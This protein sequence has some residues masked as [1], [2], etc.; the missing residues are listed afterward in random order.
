MKF[1][2]NIESLPDGIVGA[3]GGGLHKM[4]IGSTDGRQWA[5]IKK[6]G[7][8][9]DLREF[10]EHIAEKPINCYS[11]SIPG[12]KSDR[13]FAF[14][15]VDG[16]PF[17]IN[18]INACKKIAQMMYYC[19]KNHMQELW[20]IDSSE[21]EMLR[22]AAEETEYPPPAH[23]TMQHYRTMGWM[24]YPMTDEYS[25]ILFDTENDAMFCS[26]ENVT[27]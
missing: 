27:I 17:E 6:N 24:Y 25:E 3:L 5:N 20:N 19:K 9:E 23:L 11:F 21:E 26:A 8:D 2:L 1:G 13:V 16:Q 10:F 4:L 12:D 18:D 22:L 7:Y 14:A 15:R